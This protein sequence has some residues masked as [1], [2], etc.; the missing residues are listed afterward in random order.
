MK[1]VSIGDTLHIAMHFTLTCWSILRSAW[2]QGSHNVVTCGWLPMISW[3]WVPLMSAFG[4]DAGRSGSWCQPDG[5][6]FALWNSHFWLLQPFECSQNFLMTH[7]RCTNLLH[8]VMRVVCLIFSVLSLLPM[9]ILCLIP[10]CMPCSASVLPFM[11]ADVTVALILQP[12]WSTAIERWGKWSSAADTSGSWGCSVTTICQR[13]PRCW[14]RWGACPSACKTNA[15]SASCARSTFPGRSRC[16]PRTSG[17]NPRMWVPPSLPDDPSPSR[18]SWWVP[19]MSHCRTSATFAPTWSRWWRRSESRKSGT[20]SYEPLSTSYLCF[21]Y[22]GSISLGDRLWSIQGLFR[23]S[24]TL[25]ILLF[26]CSPSIN[27]VLLFE[28]GFQSLGLALHRFC[29]INAVS[30]ESFNISLGR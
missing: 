20:S 24:G 4:S 2:W 13:H 10:L 21:F 12:T 25:T 26:L 7:F 17:W 19:L 15:P 23:S 28:S 8:V 16:C 11:N 5:A 27:I 22:T 6:H 1:I 30:S 14:R 29:T 3:M 18:T 9:A